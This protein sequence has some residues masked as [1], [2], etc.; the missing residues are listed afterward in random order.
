MRARDS[1][2][3]RFR[4]EFLT[5][6]R[7][8]PQQSSLKPPDCSTPVCDL[9]STIVSGK[10]SVDSDNF[11][12]AGVTGGADSSTDPH[13]LRHNGSLSAPRTDVAAYIAYFD[14]PSEESRVFRLWIQGSNCRA[15][16]RVGLHRESVPPP[17]RW[18]LRATTSTLGD[19][20]VL[21]QTFHLMS[22]SDHM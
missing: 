2:G 13:D 11:L 8:L 18:P 10:R 19:N 3:F 5:L 9:Q 21:I 22:R 14:H 12:P 4:F 15:S 6:S 17:T 1:T 7:T 16:I 20:Q